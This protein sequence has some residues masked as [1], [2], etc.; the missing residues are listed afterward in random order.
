MVG[1]PPGTGSILD[2]DPLYRL[3]RD[4]SLTLAEPGQIFTLASGE[5]STYFFDLKKVML[6]PDGINLLADRVLDR[7]IESGVHHV[8]GLVM[9]AVPVVV[10][11]VVKSL[12]RD[13]EL[14]GFWVRKEQKDHGTRRKV[15]GYLVPGTKVV[16]VEDVTT[17]GGSV[18]KAIAEARAEGC[19]VVAVITIVD[20][21][22]GA[23]EL[24]RD[25]GVAL[26]PLYRT[27]D[28]IG[29]AAVR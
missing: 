12:A 24:L 4:R 28:F 29:D 13:W 6:D 2:R 3:I 7:I 18:L 20:R 5:K 22:Q 11:T 21:Q 23:E 27:S 10:A 26:H 15:D 1:N 9:G 17:K 19:E 8:G 16:I 14:R 25:H